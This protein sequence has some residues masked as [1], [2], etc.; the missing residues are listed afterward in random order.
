MSARKLTRA[1][2]RKSAGHGPAANTAR[3]QSRPGTGAALTIKDLVSYK[4]HVVANLLSRGAA[5]RYRRQFGVGLWEWRA[6]ALLGAEAPQSLSALAR[7]AGLDKSQMSRVVA[8][9]IERGLV[10]RDADE[11]D[12]RGVQLSLSKAGAGVHLGL[13]RAAVE[14]NEAFLNCLTPSERTYFERALAKIAQE[15]RVFIQR[16]TVLNSAPRIRRAS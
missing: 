13:M 1:N 4:L 8:G 11:R 16:E 2:S 15:A 6:I 7:S 12:G 10:A 3:G 9:L 5:M 14:R